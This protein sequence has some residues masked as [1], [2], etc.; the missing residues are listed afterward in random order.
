[1]NGA[2]QA[3]VE[4]TELRRQRAVHMLGLYE[5]CVISLTAQVQATCERLGVSLEE[6]RA[7]TFEQREAMCRAH[8]RR[9]RS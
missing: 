7:L 5:R 9:S 1:M 3:L 2:E 8:R 4:V 6:W